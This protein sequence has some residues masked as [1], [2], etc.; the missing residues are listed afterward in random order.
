MSHNLE[1]ELQATQYK[2]IFFL[3]DDDIHNVHTVGKQI[4]NQQEA[5]F[6][7]F[8]AWTEYK[9]DFTHYYTD[10]VL[11]E[12]EKEEDLMWNDL[13]LADIDTEFVV[14]QTQLAHRLHALG[15][16]FEAYLAALVAFHEII[17]NIIVRKG[18]GSFERFR[19][20]KKIAGIQ[21]CIVIDAYNS[22]SNATIKEQNEAL[23]SMSTPVTRLWN[24]VL[25]L[26]IV[27]ILDSQRAKGVMTAVLQEIATH[28][29][30]VFIIDISGIAV[31]DTAV[32]NY[33]IQ[34]TRATQLMG[35]TSVLSGITPI[36]AQTIVELNIRTDGLMTT[37]DLQDALKKAFHLVGAEIVH[38][39]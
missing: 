23:L 28:Q 21:I 6:D 5:A 35:C 22:I 30:K 7:E 9:N 20:F 3:Q 11:D 32:A 39:K 8:Y 13:L 19:S 31:M 33:L 16:P 38:K 25:F 24:G 18:F 29:S 34:L 4:L 27:G 14:R 36:V 1:A 15:I 26:P 2:K 37:G 10:E 12:M 17:E